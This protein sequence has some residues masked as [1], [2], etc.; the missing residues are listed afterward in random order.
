[1]IFLWVD[2]MLVKEESNRE[3]A[4]LGQYLQWVGVMQP[5]TDKSRSNFLM[6]IVFQ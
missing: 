5:D 1:M 4:V 3:S 2:F 6:L